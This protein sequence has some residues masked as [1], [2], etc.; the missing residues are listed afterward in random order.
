MFSGN[1]ALTRV[2]EQRLPRVHAPHDCGVVCAGR[3]QDGQ[4]HARGGHLPDA[5]LV[6]GVAAHGGAVERLARLEVGHEAVGLGAQPVGVRAELVGVQPFAG[7]RCGRRRHR[8]LGI[9]IDEKLE[10]SKY[11][12]FKR[13]KKIP[14]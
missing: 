2:L 12:R 6:A 7:G 10:L 9:G 1:N 13:C 11:V 3:A 8:G 14:T 5:V 4:P